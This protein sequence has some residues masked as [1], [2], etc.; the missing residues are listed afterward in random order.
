MTLHIEVKFDGVVSVN[1]PD[2]LSKGDA[3]ILAGKIALARVVAVT[4]N[5]DAPEEESFEEYC[6]ECSKKAKKTAEQDWD[7]IGDKDM[8]VGG[9]WYVDDSAALLRE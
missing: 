8:S 1:V 5:P 7:R 2:H 4:D 6:E 3:K 9:D